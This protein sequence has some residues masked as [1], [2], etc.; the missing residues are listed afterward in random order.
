MKVSLF[1]TDFRDLLS[2]IHFS[3]VRQSAQALE[4]MENPKKK[5]RGDHGYSAIVNQ[6]PEACVCVTEN[7]LEAYLNATD[8]RHVAKESLVENEVQDDHYV[9]RRW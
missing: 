7:P 5:Y 6:D 8:E 9:H 4:T 2:Q 3:V 1:K